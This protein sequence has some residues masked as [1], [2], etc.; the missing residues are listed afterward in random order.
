MD[1]FDILEILRAGLEAK[2]SGGNVQPIPEKEQVKRLKIFAERKIDFKVGERVA[3]NEDG[4]NRY[5]FPRKDQVA[6]VTSVFDK[7]LL[8]EQGMVAHGE[9]GVVIRRPGTQE[10]TVISHPVDFRYYK[11]RPHAV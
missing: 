2:Q 8:D 3:R 4:E 11:R 5:K 10:D 7:P 1:N 9:I 6:I